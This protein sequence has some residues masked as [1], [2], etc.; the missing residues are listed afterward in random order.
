MK[1]TNSESKEPIALKP[2]PHPHSWVVLVRLLKE[3]ADQNGI[4]H[5]QI[6]D[7]TGLIRSHI[8]RMFAGRFC[9]RLDLFLK[10]ANSV[11][12]N[13]FIQDMNSQIDLNQAMEKAME[14]LGRRP[15]RSIKN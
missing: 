12:V 6:A 8:S 2:Q 10:V 11:G 15:D 3:I 4:S 14:Y 1:K 13:F 9:P 5:Q 7:E